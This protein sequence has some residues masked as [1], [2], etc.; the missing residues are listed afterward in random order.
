ML[1]EGSDRELLVWDQQRG[2]TYE[3]CGLFLLPTPGL[4]IHRDTF[5]RNDIAQYAESIRLACVNEKHGFR[6]G[7]SQ[8]AAGVFQVAVA[9]KPG[10]VS[11]GEWEDGIGINATAVKERASIFRVRRLG[12]SDLS[13]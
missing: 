10:R 11:L 2:W 13:Q 6:G 5:S 1:S 12:S 9:G 7:I 3:S 4:P 8:I